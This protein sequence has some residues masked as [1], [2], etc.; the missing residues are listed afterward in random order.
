LIGVQNTVRNLSPGGAA[1]PA[2]ATDTLATL[3]GSGATLTQWVRQ[4]ASLPVEPAN[5]IVRDDKTG[6]SYFIG[7]DGYRRWIPTGGDYLCFTGQGGPVVNLARISVDT[8]PEHVGSP[9]KC[10][11]EPQPPAPP[12]PSEGTHT[13]QEGHHG[14]NTF[15]DPHNASG[16]GPRVEA[17]QSVDVSCKLYDPSIQSANPG[18]YWYR[19]A[20]SPWNDQYYAPANTFMNADPWDGPYTHDTD[21]SVP[22]C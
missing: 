11:A 21:L 6:A 17:A 2:R 14:V 9:A 5:T 1:D 13:E 4:T 7:S 22:D 3:P 12:A 18:G 10:S 16:M 15:T 8:I 19:I 20:S